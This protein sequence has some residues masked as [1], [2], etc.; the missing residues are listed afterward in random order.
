MIGFIKAETYVVKRISNNTDVYSMEVCKEYLAL[1]RI[2]IAYFVVEL[3]REVHA[4]YL[5]YFF[6]V[7]EESVGHE[8]LIEGLMREVE[9]IACAC[10]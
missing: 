1:V 2:E 3:Q 5:S 9:R 8:V 7:D 10:E 4:V 6:R